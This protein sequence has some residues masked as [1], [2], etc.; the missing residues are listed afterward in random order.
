MESDI[1]HE[2]ES[3]LSET[4]QTLNEYKQELQDKNQYFE[5]KNRSSDG[6][7]FVFSYNAITWERINDIKQKYVDQYWWD[8]EWIIVVND[9]WHEI[10]DYEIKKTTKIYLKINR[11]K[12]PHPIMFYDVS[13]AGD[14]KYVCFI[15]NYGRTPHNIKQ[16]Y[17][18]QVDKVIPEE[19][20]LLLDEN[21]E[22]Y[23][24][25]LKFKPRDVIT[26]KFK[27]SESSNEISKIEQSIKQNHIKEHFEEQNERMTEEK[28]WKEIEDHHI[29]T[30]PH[31]QQGIHNTESQEKV[32]SKYKYMIEKQWTPLSHWNKNN[33]EISLTFDDWYGKTYIVNILNT[34]RWAWIKATFFLLWECVKNSSYLREQAIKDW[35]QICCHTYSHA[36][37]SE[38]E[39]TEL[40]K[41]HWISPQRRLSLVKA[42]D[43]NVKRLLWTDYY[44]NIKSENPWMPQVMDS[45]TLLE[46]EILMW[47][48][49]VKQ[50][51]WEDYL[52]E[53][54]LNHPFFRFP[55]GC[56]SNRMENIDVLKKHWYLA[57][58]WNGEPKYKIPEKIWNWDI[59]LFHFDKTNA[60]VLYQYLHKLTTSWKEPKLVSEIILP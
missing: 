38:W 39:T 31:Q 34:L 24:E 45:A 55:G 40:F 33:P 7:Y 37:L 32:V 42:W 12:N 58:W 16:M 18:D 20:F 57:I 52:S 4:H 50:S 1:D 29:E 10:F 5:Y 27:K 22:P 28:A 59:P 46:T 41:W 11:V 17:Q 26:I 3:L 8:K 14:K 43:E 13:F 49:E 19:D 23:D 51:L 6:E 36:Y 53:M 30:H 47:E 35:H 54:K 60:P 21:N 48:E 25:S 44:N 2:N 56:W 15:E 9:K